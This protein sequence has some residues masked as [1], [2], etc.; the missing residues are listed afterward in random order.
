MTQNLRMVNYFVSEFYRKRT[1]E[2]EHI[3]S[4]SF[5]FKL[6]LNPEQSFKD[7]AER[8]NYINE[9]AKLTIEEVKSE[10][11][12]TFYAQSTLRIPDGEGEEFKAHANNIFV[13]KNG[14]LDKVSVMYDLTDQGYDR[15]QYLLRK[16][17]ANSGSSDA[18]EIMEFEQDLIE[19]I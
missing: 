6:Q 1:F 11:D 17:A 8:M 15:I 4:T 7:F 13:V 2:L 12:T 5:S 9:N 10:D 18:R 14:L 19:F 3:T 16:N